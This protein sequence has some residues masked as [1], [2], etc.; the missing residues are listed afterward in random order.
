MRSGAQ[1][2]Y[3]VVAGPTAVGKSGVALEVAE[4][5]GGEIVI[6]DSRQVYRGLEIGTAKPGAEERARVP[7]HLLDVVDLGER[8]TA[9]DFA[10]AASAA[11]EEVRSR[12]RVPVV[13]GGTGMYL[14]ALAG[15]LDPIEEEA[16]TT[17]RE[18]ARARVE[19]IAVGQRFAELERIDQRSAKRLH[20]G[21]RQRVDRALEVWFLT[22]EP[23]SNWQAGGAGPRP[24]VAVRLERPRAELAERI[25]R[26]LE[27]MLAA[28]LEREARGLWEAG[29]TSDAPGLDTIGY[30]EWWPCFEGARG[31][32]ETID[33]IRAATRQ[34]AKR[35]V[36]WFRNQ[37]RYRPLPAEGAGPV[38]A[39]LWR[40][41]R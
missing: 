2:E 22:G 29:W 1:A 4:R 21:D 26:R 36:T 35:Q 6:A 40:N 30:Q 18:A 33:A 37:G 27:A 41:T 32:E 19:A 12:D 15:A 25:D 7:H 28:G 11:I 24:H 23:L 9:A 16:G 34:Y 13:C 31:R 39:A 5:L 8:Y 17:E 3:L 38:I 10:A 20:A 14:A